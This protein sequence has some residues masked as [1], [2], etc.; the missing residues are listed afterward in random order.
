MLARQ[1]SIYEGSRLELDDDNLLIVLFSA[2]RELSDYST[3]RD[4]RSF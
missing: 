2:G 1:V 4:G 3:M